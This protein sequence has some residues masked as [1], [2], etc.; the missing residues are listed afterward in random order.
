M[1]PPPVVDIAVPAATAAAEAPEDEAPAAEEG[2]IWIP[3][4]SFPMGSETC[5]SDERPVSVVAVRGFFL[6]ATEVSAEAYQRCVSAGRCEGERPE[7]T[8][9]EDDQAR[10]NLGSKERADHPINCVTWRQ[11]DRY[12]R[13]SGKRLPTEREWEYA[14]RGAA[15][16]AF[17]WGEEWDQDRVCSNRKDGTCPIGSHRAGDTPSG[18][19]DMAGNVWEWT[20]DH[21]CPYESPECEDS[22]YVDRGGGWISED[23]HLVHSAHR[24]RG[25]PD[26]WASFLGFRCAKDR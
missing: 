10:C 22:G 20:A 4:G 12:C 24:G 1:A 18:L 19:T 15:G 23:P 9:G 6:D 5:D 13:T 26:G 2:M 7:P 11:A 17:P 3:G 16:R 21:Y 14:A 25:E 8:D